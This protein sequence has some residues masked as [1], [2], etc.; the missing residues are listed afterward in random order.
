MAMLKIGVSVC[1]VKNLP[2]N[3]SVFAFPYLIDR[4]PLLFFFLFYSF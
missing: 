1:L 3:F 4:F 2:S